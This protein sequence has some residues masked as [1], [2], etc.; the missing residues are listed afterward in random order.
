MKRIRRR[1]GALSPKCRNLDLDQHFRAD[2]VADDHRRGRCGSRR[3]SREI[4][5]TRVAKAG[6]GGRSSGCERTSDSEKPASFRAPSIVS[7]SCGCFLQPF[8]AWS[9]WRS[10]SGRAGD[11]APV[12]LRD[13]TRITCRLSK[14]EQ[15]ERSLRVI[16]QL[17][18]R[19]GSGGR[20]LVIVDGTAFSSVRRYRRGPFSSNG[21]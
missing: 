15:D 10:R 18:P 12:A 6:I 14:G 2:E 13:G 9:W 1:R 11:E 7:G 17:M 5:N 21:A 16:R 19:A 3:R 4:G 20:L 8:S